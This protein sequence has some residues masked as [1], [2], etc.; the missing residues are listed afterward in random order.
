MTRTGFLKPNLFAMIA[1][2]VKVFRYVKPRES[3]AIAGADI[4]YPYNRHIPNDR[5]RL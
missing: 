4:P 3:A 5:Q 2:A 1:T